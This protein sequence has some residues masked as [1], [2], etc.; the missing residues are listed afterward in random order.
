MEVGADRR[1]LIKLGAALAVLAAVLY[2]QFFRGPVPQPAAPRIA[3]DTPANAGNTA[4]DP[5]PTSQ[6]RGGRFQPRLGRREADEALDPLT[7]ETTLRTDLLHKV[8]AIEVPTVDRDIF[9]F[10]RPKPPP[11]QPPDPEAAREAQRRVE[12]QMRARRERAAQ[13]PPAPPPAPRARPPA[14]KYFG[15]ASREDAAA[16]RAFLLDGEEIL[17]AE[18]GL[19]VQDRYRIKSVGLDALVLAD[20]ESNQE[21]SIPLEMPR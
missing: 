14:W 3:R 9:N 1:S 8:Q 20:L 15:V 12:E 4:A 18:Q 19:V 5:Q 13:K 2:F 11:P 21:F 17:V 16:Q 7:A 6:P 10:G